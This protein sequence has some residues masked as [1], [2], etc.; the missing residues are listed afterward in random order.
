MTHARG[1]TTLA[2]YTWTFDASGRITGFTSPDGSA[3]Y[4]Y[5]SNGQLTAVD[6]STLADEGY[7]YDANGNR[8]MSGYVTDDDNRLTS[9]G[10]YS[11]E[12][13][14]EGNRTKRTH[15]ASGAYVEYTYD[16]RN[17]LTR[18]AR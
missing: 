1:G 17:G 8:T 5:D 3:T 14:A 12:Y 10:T 16:H 15:A 13:D 6:N 11:Y 18:A 2:G 7:S 9:D 4:S